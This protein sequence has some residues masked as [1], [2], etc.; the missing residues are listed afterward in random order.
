MSAGSGILHSERNESRTEPVRF[1]QM[2]VVPDETAVTPSYSQHEIG[3][4]LLDGGLVT[5]VSGIPRHEAP[6][7]LHN[8]NAALHATRL[9]PGGSVTLPTA[10][11]LHLFVARGRVTADGIGDLAEGDAARFTD[12]GARRVSAREP[13]ELLI[14]EMHAKLGADST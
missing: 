6:I 5:I 13:S 12:A 1:V 3:A 2:W 11:Y 10:P 14:W 7:T 9:R 4:D 8:R